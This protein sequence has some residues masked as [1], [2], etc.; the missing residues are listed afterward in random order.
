MKLDSESPEYL[1]V[2]RRIDKVNFENVNL[3][4]VMDLLDSILCFPGNPLRAWGI[5]EKN[6]IE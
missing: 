3:A 2:I 1:L 5:E 6:M 4:R